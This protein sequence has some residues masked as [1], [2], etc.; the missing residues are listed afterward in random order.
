MALMYSCPNLK[1][2]SCS[3]FSSNCYFL[4][5][6]Q[7]SQ[8]SVQV[9]W[10]SHL[11]KNFPQFVVIY[12]VKGIGVINKAAVDVFMEFSCFFYDAMDVAHLISGS[13]AFCK[14][15]LNIWKFMVHILLKPG[16]E[17]FEHYIASIWDECNEH[18]LAMSFF[19]IG[20]KTDIF[21]VL[22]KNCWVFKI[23]W[24]IECSTFTTSSLK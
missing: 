11:L 12:T 23:C 1:S 4:T 16:L 18:S 19:G 10:Y 3:M 5:C 2:V 17:N 24:H 20:V 9:L 6:I 22:W 14:S 8:D 7:I 15:S 21:P 13:S